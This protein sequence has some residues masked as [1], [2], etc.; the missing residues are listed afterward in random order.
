MRRRE[1]RQKSVPETVRR[2]AFFELGIS[3]RE[4]SL[5]IPSSLKEEEIEKE[6]GK[7]HDVRH[8]AAIG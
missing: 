3:R 4:K 1:I 8:V 2:P 5:C 6:E 7:H